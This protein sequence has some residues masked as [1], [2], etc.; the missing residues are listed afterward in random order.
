MRQA[1]EGISQQSR[2]E[3]P[4]LL[5]RGQCLSQWPHRAGKLVKLTAWTDAEN[6]KDAL[7]DLAAAGCDH[8]AYICA[9]L[10]DDPLK[11]PGPG[12]RMLPIRRFGMPRSEEN[13]LLIF[14]S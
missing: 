5:R 3:F 12:S 13:D 11:E 7:R 4:I 14:S 2:W 1:P 6:G 8:Q 9:Y 10:C